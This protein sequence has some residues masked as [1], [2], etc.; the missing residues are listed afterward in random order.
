M[1]EPLT[2]EAFE[3]FERH[4]D[5]TMRSIATTLGDHTERLE[6]IEQ[7]L[8]RGQRL[9]EAERRITELAKTVGRPDLA[10]PFTRPIGA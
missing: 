6:R 7:I 9:E 2:V 8:W 3:K 10:T 5:E 4:F 1:P